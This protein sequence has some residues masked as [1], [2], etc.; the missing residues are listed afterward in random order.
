MFYRKHLGDAWNKIRGT[1]SQ[2]II[3]G[4]TLAKANQV[5]DLT[6]DS[7]R[8]CILYDDM[9]PMALHVSYVCYMRNVMKR[10]VYDMI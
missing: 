7:V 9:C 6:V 3:L 5:N 2:V 10:Y 8:N 4:R 1:S